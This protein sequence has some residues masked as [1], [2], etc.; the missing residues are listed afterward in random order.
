MI[1]R[2][3][4]REAHLAEETETALGGTDAAEHRTELG[5]SAEYFFSCRHADGTNSSQ[6]LNRM[7]KLGDI[8]ERICPI[9]NVS[10]ATAPLVMRYIGRDRRADMASR[11]RLWKKD[12]LS[13]SVR[14]GLPRTVAAS[15][16]IVSARARHPFF[17]SSA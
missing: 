17:F 3:G 4:E 14:P 11:R 8:S 13:A 15:S 16:T 6:G 7:P 1:S 2:R 9:G 5:S 12:P 10:M